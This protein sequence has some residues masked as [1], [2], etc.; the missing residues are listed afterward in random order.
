MWLKNVTMIMILM[1]LD[2]KIIKSNK[3][4]T[5]ARGKE[6]GGA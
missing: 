2:F 1:I 3:F 5:F 4:S 6:L